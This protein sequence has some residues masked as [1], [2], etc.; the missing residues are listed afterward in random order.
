MFKLFY[1]ELRAVTEEYAVQKL[2]EAVDAFC[3]EHPE[4]EPVCCSTVEIVN[5]YYP[6]GGGLRGRAAKLTVG[7]KTSDAKLTIGRFL[8]NPVGDA[9]KSL[10]A[11]TAEQRKEVFAEWCTH[12]GGDTPCNCM[13]DE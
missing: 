7:F 9:K 11:L 5:D 1:V 10:A 4:L 13:R 8:T 12:C 3:K 6:V 2:Q